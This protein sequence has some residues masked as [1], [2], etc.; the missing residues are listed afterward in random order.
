MA[1]TRQLSTE[2]GT[3][4]VA[5]IAMKADITDVEMGL[6]A[7]EDD[8]RGI[9]WDG[10]SPNAV[11]QVATFRT[12][13]MSNYSSPTRVANVDISAFTLGGTNYLA[14]L[15]GGS[16]RGSWQ[17]SDELGGVT[18]YWI[19]K[20]PVIQQ[21]GATVELS[22]PNGTTANAVR[23]I[24][25]GM[26]DPTIATAISGRNVALSITINGVAITLPMFIQNGVIRLG[27]PNTQKVILTLSGRSDGSSTYPV[28]PT[29][30]TSLLEKTINSY[31]TP[32]SFTFTP[33]ATN[34]SV[35]TGEIV[36]TS[37]GFDFND[38]AIIKTSYEWQSHGVVTS[39]PDS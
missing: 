3:F 27:G 13:A 32:Q 38:A 23:S 35:F 15:R 10:E 11:K 31:A 22:I 7:Q 30:T 37:F 36:P 1:I 33:K 12:T 18:D 19:S 29:G 21:F 26:M 17:M 8:G 14:Y 28:A 20:V 25:G 5:S 2:L 6:Q 24:I 4:T 34:S 16:F 9:A 39:T